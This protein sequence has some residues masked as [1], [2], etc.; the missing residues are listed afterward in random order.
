MSKRALTTLTAAFLLWAVAPGSASA[1]QQTFDACYVPEVGALYLINLSGLPTECLSTDHVQVNWTEG[2]GVTDHGNLAGLADDDHPEYVREGEA[3][4]GDLA[5]TFPDPSV[6]GLQGNPLSSTAP[7]DG[8]VLAWNGTKMEWE[9]QD[10][11]SLSDTRLKTEVEPLGAALDGLGSIRP[12]RFRFREDT[13]QPTDVQIGL[14]A[15][16][17]EEI[18]PELV[19]RDGQGYLRLAYPK[20]TAVLLKGLQEQQAQIEEK[21]QAIERLEEQNERLADRLERLEETVQRLQEREP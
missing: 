5:G 9:P 13:G 8:Q 4:A 17:V 19:T 3:A 16:E 2:G 1:Q 11:G 21:D 15:Q 20:L 12:V 14:I 7:S 6:A 18:F 10:P